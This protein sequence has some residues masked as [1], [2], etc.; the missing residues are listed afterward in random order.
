MRTHRRLRLAA[1]AAG[2]ALAL[3]ACSTPPEPALQPAAQPAPAVSAAPATPPAP[4]PQLSAE[5]R[6]TAYGVP[7]IK[8]KDYAGLGYGVGYAAAEDNLCE[9][10]ERNITVNAERAKYLGPGEDGRNI[11]SDLYHRALIEEGGMER[12]LN[13][14]PGSVD[15]PSPQA[16]AIARGYAAGVSRYLR[17]VGPEGVTDPRCRGAAWLRPLTEADYW[18]H[19]YAGQ[20]IYQMNGVVSA[21]P[22]GVQQAALAP[23]DPL[24]ETQGLGSNAY[25]IGREAAKGGRAVLLGNPHYPW[26]GQNRFYRI[27]MTIPGE[28]DVVGAGL[29]T[30][31]TV[32]IGHTDRIAWTH[33]VSTARRFG[34]FELTLNPDNPTEYLH[35]GR[36]IP[37]EARNVSVEV[38]TDEGVRR[39]TRRLYSTRFGPVVETETLP[40]TKERAFAFRVMPTGLRTVDQYID[41]W[42]AKSVRE[43]FAALA[44]HQATGFN[45]TAVDA[46]G[47]ALFGDLGMVPHVTPAHAAQCSISDLARKM[48]AETAVPVLDAS[49]AACDWPDDPGATAKGVFASARM[50][51]MFR[52]DYVIQ[53]ND[54]HWLTN[55]E[56]PLEGYS[57]V[58]GDERTRRS[59]RT[60]LAL[61]LVRDR[62]AGVDGYAGKAFDLPTLKQVMFNN[63][64]LGAELVR[65]DL[66]ALCRANAGRGVRAETCAALAAWDLKVDLDSRGA[67]VFHLFADKGGLVFTD[68]FRPDAAVDTPA[69][70]AVK[71]RK[72][73]AALKAADEELIRLNLAPDAA[74]GT[75]QAETRNGVRIPIHGGAGQEGVFNV[76]SVESLEP[77]LGWTSIRHGSSWVMVVEFTE[78]GPVSEGLLTYSQ[79]TNPASPHHSDQ[80][81]LYSQKGWDD[82]R[83]SEKAVAAGTLSRKVVEE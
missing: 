67:H 56:T 47:E 11:A 4:P 14:P 33:T 54:S 13:G 42:K 72:V 29:V 63:R 31:A 69:R 51:H 53:S 17:E 9:L 81:V 44:K 75:V 46:V 64:H 3:A 58:F 74:L 36:Y 41:I 82:L 21:A 34:Y 37:M 71:D 73:L 12:L 45:T 6:R 27:H 52:T 68:P 57:P 22:P 18:R 7:H 62:R 1:A 59:L 10:A 70:L 30:N 60:R 24:P 61:D 8:A 32:G 49:R 83:F 43:L 26:D 66:V 50:P 5:I 39:E 55:A 38:K 2:A 65:A 25:G 19:V 28:L 16:R 40:W 35:E 76:I 77:D 78:D 48:W 20:V 23:D 79:S 80:T 15:T